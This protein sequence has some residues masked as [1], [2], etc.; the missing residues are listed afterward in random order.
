MC[1]GSR[2]CNLE[3]SANAHARCSA[4]SLQYLRAFDFANPLS[5]SVAKE[6][7]KQT[8]CRSLESVNE[9]CCV[10]IVDSCENRSPNETA[11]E[12]QRLVLGSPLPQFVSIRPSEE[13]LCRDSSERARER[14]RERERE[15]VA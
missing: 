14:E 7:Q 13:S 4:A 12:W 1:A 9:L 11:A 5:L 8:A 6:E 10:F 15:R 2:K 3:Q